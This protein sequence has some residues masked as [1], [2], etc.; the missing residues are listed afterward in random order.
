MPLKIK[1]NNPNNNSQAADAPPQATI[2]LRLTKTLAGNYLIKDH[3]LLD[4]VVESKPNEPMAASNTRNPFDPFIKT[5]LINKKT[6][7]LRYFQL[8]AKSFLLLDN[9]KSYIN[10]DCQN[11][12]SLYCTLKYVLNS[13][14]NSLSTL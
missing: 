11:S 8:D 13:M 9:L 1:I 3:R 7:L 6:K 10:L 4:I 5:I 14:L 2:E 12:S